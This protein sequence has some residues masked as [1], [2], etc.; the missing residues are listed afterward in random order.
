MNQVLPQDFCD[1]LNVYR[2]S[3]DLNL[4]ILNINTIKIWLLV[5]PENRYNITLKLNLSDQTLEKLNTLENENWNIDDLK[6]FQMDPEI[7]CQKIVCISELEWSCIQKNFPEL[8]KRELYT[9]IADHIL[10]TNE[11]IQRIALEPQGTADWL[12]HRKGRLTGSNYGNA[13]GINPYAGG[14]PIE[15][16][17][18]MLFYEEM[19]E[20]GQKACKHGN[21]HE[22]LAC[23]C[24]E[25]LK[26]KLSRCFPNLSVDDKEQI[27]TM[28]QVEHRGLE[29]HPFDPWSGDSKDGIVYFENGEEE[30]FLLEIKCPTKGDTYPEIPPYYYSQIQGIAYWNGYK[31]IDFFVFTREK[32]EIS[33]YAYDHEYVNDFLLP[34]LR[35]WW[36][37]M[38]L[39]N[40]VL[41]TQGKITRKEQIKDMTMDL[42]VP[43]APHLQSIDPTYFMK[44]GYGLEKKKKTFSK[45]MFVPSL[46]SKTTTASTMAKYYP[47]TDS[48][49]EKVEDYPFSF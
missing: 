3:K 9:Y 39:P 8:T 26:V 10:V 30:P 19:D 28:I 22:D 25:Y 48:K 31:K 4:F 46:N 47:K 17:R 7:L 49:K 23:D 13:S 12:N 40:A 29:V 21:T 45:P 24:Y 36:F 20:R 15:L 38:F 11:D 1:A 43:T 18:S 37:C 5:Q 42:F 16:V 34:R 44:L 32:C 27:S 2:W 6:E 41:Y 14:S 35:Y 33:T